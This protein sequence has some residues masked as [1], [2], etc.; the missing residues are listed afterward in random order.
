VAVPHLPELHLRHSLLLRQG[1]LGSG[2]VQGRTVGAG[3]GGGQR[4]T[5]PSQLG[6]F[7]SQG[8][9][10][11]ALL[12]TKGLQLRLQRVALPLQLLHLGVKVNKG[13][14]VSLSLQASLFSHLGQGCSRPRK[15]VLH[16]FLHH[17]GLLE[18]QPLP[19]HQH[20]FLN[21]GCFGLRVLRKASRQGYQ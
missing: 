9:L 20:G 11:P 16:R 6:L 3:Y 5:K 15:G 12:S 7:G 1:L 8:G 2:K 17:R 10:I 14:T 13:S 21:F 19:L 18:G 4:C